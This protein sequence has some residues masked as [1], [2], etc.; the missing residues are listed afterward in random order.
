[1]ARAKFDKA[2]SRIEA[3]NAE[4]QRG[5]EERIDNEKRNMVGRTQRE[6][7]LAI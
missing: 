6:V 2:K 1:M 7:D 5:I 4:I 3:V